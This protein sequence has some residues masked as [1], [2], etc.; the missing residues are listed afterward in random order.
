MVQAKLR[1]LHSPDVIDLHT[2][3]PKDIFLEKIMCSWKSLITK[4]FGKRF[5][6]SANEQQGIIGIVSL[7]SSTVILHGSSRIKIMDIGAK[8]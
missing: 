6:K 1:R 5:Q 3:A 8:H 7:V 2:F 4:Y